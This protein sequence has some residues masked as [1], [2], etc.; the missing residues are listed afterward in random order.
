MVLDCDSL[1][2]EVN[3][4]NNYLFLSLYFEHTLATSSTENKT[5]N[6]LWNS[7]Y[8]LANRLR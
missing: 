7:A 5:M 2:L 6:T 1:F 3:I 8:L 4:Y